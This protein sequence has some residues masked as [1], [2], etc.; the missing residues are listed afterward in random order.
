MRFN[1][2]ATSSYLGNQILD[3][4]KVILYDDVQ[5]CYTAETVH[6]INNLTDLRAPVQQVWPVTKEVVSMAGTHAKRLP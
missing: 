6:G 2:L 1:D 5:E 4:S 3:Q